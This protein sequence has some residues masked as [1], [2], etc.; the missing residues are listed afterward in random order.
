VCTTLRDASV[1]VSPHPRQ[2]ALSLADFE[3]RRAQLP[4]A[5]VSMAAMASSMPPIPQPGA[6]ATVATP[7]T[8]AQP[9]TSAQHSAQQPR[10]P[11]GTAAAATPANQAQPSILDS[12]PDAFANHSGSPAL[13]QMS[14]LAVYLQ[15]CDDEARKAEMIQASG[16]THMC[17][18]ARKRHTKDSCFQH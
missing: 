1:D 8:A 9:A 5:F 4:Q 15:D 11:N 3:G 17:L 16:D 18:F 10:Q 2:E 7:V 12:V 14:H 13:Q 6:A